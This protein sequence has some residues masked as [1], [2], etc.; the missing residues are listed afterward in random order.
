M[1]YILNIF[2][3]NNNSH[4]DNLVMLWHRILGQN[5]FHHNHLNKIKI[6]MSDSD[7]SL[8]RY[9]ISQQTCYRFGNFKYITTF[10][11]TWYI[12]S[13]CVQM[14]SNASCS[15]EMNVNFHKLHFI[16]ICL[17]AYSIQT[18]EIQLDLEMLHHNN[19][20]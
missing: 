19:D 20:Q 6:Q 17:K 15:S 3:I 14:Y 13:I 10:E 5:S 2:Q 18:L 11:T 7:I 9:V 12:F 8:I 16:F 4:L 1:L